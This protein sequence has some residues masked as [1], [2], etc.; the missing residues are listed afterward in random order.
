MP[1]SARLDDERV[2]PK[3]L[4][5]CL[6]KLSVDNETPFVEYLG[7]HYDSAVVRVAYP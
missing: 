1:R 7:K 5:C 2:E 6:K 4:K 3:G